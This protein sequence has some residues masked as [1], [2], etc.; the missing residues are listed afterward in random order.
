MDFSLARRNM[1]DSQVRT[2][3]V[4]DAR[5]LDALEAVPREAFVPDAFKSIA[6]RDGDVE[7]GAGRRLLDPMVFARLVQEAHIQPTEVVLD[8]GCATGYSTAVLARLATTVVA[9]ESDR[10]LAGR[11]AA[12]LAELGVDNVAVVEGQL[13]EGEKAHGP[14]DV[15]MVE[16]AVAETPEALLAQLAEGGRL[17]AITKRPGAVSAATLTLRVG[18][19]FSTRTLFEVAAPVLPGFARQPGFVF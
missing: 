2:N 13:S 16:G 8:V 3:R 4:T 17:L 12:L 5:L 10:A 15:V 19:S 9:L 18:G 6:Y 14:Y 1:V 7:V 11:A